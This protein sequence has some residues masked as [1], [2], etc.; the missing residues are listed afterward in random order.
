MA[1]SG[2]SNAVATVGPPQRLATVPIDIQAAGPNGETSGN[3][4]AVAQTG[5]DGTII[6]GPSA[7]QFPASLGA[8]TAAASFSITPASDAQFLIDTGV[9][10]PANSASWGGS[11]SFPKAGEANLPM[12]VVTGVQFGNTAIPAMGDTNGSFVVAKG[13]ASG[14]LSSARVLTGATG[15]IKASAGQLYSLL[16]VRNANAGVRYLHLYNKATA[17]TLSTDTPILTIALAASSVQNAIDL[18]NIGAEFTTG[19]AWAFTTDNIAIPA[20]AGTSTELMFS[21]VYK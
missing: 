13:S 12:A 5:A 3:A 16:S 15:V 21:A 1:I 14:G 8:K 2:S 19:I 17:P 9:S 6:S 18:T 4:L 10:V 20:T 11:I 7:T